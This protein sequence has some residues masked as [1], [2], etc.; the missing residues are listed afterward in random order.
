MAEYTIAPATVLLPCP[1][2]LTPAEGAALLVAGITAIHC[3]NDCAHLQAGE[4]ILI[5]AAAG[6][7]GTLAVQIAKSMGAKVIGTASSAR[8]CQTV[9]S[10]GALAINYT[11][12]DWVK[13]VKNAT[14]GR[15]ADVILESVGGEIF[16]RSFKEALATFGR[17]VVF[18]VASTEVVSIDNREILESNKTLAGYYL[19]DY[20]PAHLDRVMSA[21]MKL[22]GLIREGTVKPV[23]GKTFPLDQAVDAFNHMQR[24]ESIGKVI[25]TP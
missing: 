7:V 15:G 6:G 5:H 3:I 16:K 22:V 25:I 1:D 8:K 9:T 23:I 4:S 12:G 19:G 24:R 10:L 14:E 13:E 20:I 11:E 21:T 17:M 2:E 18:G